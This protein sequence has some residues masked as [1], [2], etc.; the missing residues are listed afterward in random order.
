MF[1]VTVTNNGN[2]FPLRGTNWA[3]SMDRAQVF[4]TRDDAAAALEKARK[5]MKPAMFKRAVIKELAPA[6]DSLAQ[7]EEESRRYRAIHGGDGW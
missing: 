6:S 7:A 4:A 1:I 2:E 5:F 3:Y